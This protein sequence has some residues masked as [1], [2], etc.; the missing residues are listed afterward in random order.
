MIFFFIIVRWRLGFMWRIRPL[1]IVLYK[2]VHVNNM[3]WGC[4]IN[5][6]HWPKIAFLCYPVS[7]KFLP[8]LFFFFFFLV[9]SSLSLFDPPGY[10]GL[11]LTSC[12]GGEYTNKLFR[13]LMKGKNDLFFTTYLFI[14][15]FVYVTIGT[16]TYCALCIIIQYY[17][18]LFILLKLF[19]V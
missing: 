16:H 10:G 1:F 13:M 5:F 19:Q 14:Q 12:R 7:R 11:R 6:S 9:S 17:I 4:D 15:L 3:I 18:D 2:G 8:F